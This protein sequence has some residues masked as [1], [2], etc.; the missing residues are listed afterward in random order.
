MINPNNIEQLAT[1]I[2]HLGI[3]IDQLEK[4]YNKRSSEKFEKTKK[5]ILEIC[6]NISKII[7]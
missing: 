5:E 6:D 1:L 3:L 2:D 7:E 4:F